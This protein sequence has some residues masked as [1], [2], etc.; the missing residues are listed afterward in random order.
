MPDDIDDDELVD[1]GDRLGQRQTHHREGI[2]PSLALLAAP[3]G[4]GWSWKHSQ[5]LFRQCVYVCAH[6]IS[7][8]QRHKRRLGQLPSNQTLK[9]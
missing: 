5:L 3:G 7:Q 8:M 4:H 9:D 6:I 1:A 2:G